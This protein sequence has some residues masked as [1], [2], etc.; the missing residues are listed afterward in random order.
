MLAEMFAS[1]IVSEESALFIPE[2]FAGSTGDSIGIP[3]IAPPVPAHQATF[4]H[5][6]SVSES[7]PVG[8]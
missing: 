7:R 8:N 2:D 6:P 1:K 4:P 3:A 5:P